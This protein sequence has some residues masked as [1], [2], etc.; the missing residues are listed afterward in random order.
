MTE[1]T[2]TTGTFC[3]NEL[4][5][6]DADAATSFYK[7]LFGW[8]T[9]DAPMPGDMPGRYVLFKLGDTDI[10]GG[11]AMVGEMFEGVP[12]HW[13]SYVA[14]DDVDAALA[15][16]EQ[17][18]AHVVWPAMDV[19]DIGRMACFEDPTG[20]R[21][22]VFKSA[23]KSDRPDL[24]RRLNAFCWYELN[25]NDLAKASAF[26]TELLGWKADRKPGP[27]PYTEWMLDGCVVGGALQ[28]DPAW[29][30]IPPHWQVYVSVA[31]CDA[32]AAKA[33]ELGGRVELPPTDIPEVGRA[34]VLA[35]PTGA[36]IAVITLSGEH[37]P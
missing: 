32:T 19:P 30:E 24:G 12:S 29:G 2:T 34:A 14:V 18:G 28:M 7:A 36:D 5:T 3:W 25:T 23:G 27:T 31:D 33:Q 15:K 6:A 1:Q 37:A 13:L 22:A 16:A 11:Y 35:D 17:L 9:E 10:G 20:A 26:Y 4:A 8:K 21:L